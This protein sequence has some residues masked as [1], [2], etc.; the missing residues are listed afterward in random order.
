M[1]LAWVDLPQPLGPIIKRLSAMINMLT[2]RNYTFEQR[3]QSCGE[4]QE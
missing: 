4:A 1:S 3:F 2:Y